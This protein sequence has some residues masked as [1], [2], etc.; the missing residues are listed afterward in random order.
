LIVTVTPTSEVGKSPFHV[1]V[2]LARLL[3]Y[4]EIQEP[5]WIVFDELYSG[6]IPPGLMAGPMTVK[7]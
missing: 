3:P 2:A 7:L 6:L 1:A 4:I 5:G